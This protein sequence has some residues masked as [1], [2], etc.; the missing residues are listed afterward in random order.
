MTG[1]IAD[2]V[3]ALLSA[4]EGSVGPVTE[5][6]ALPPEMY[7][8]DQVFELEREAIFARDWLC[9][10][11]VDQ[12][13]EPGDYRTVT[14]AGEP[15]IVTRGRTGDIRVLSAV[16]Q[17]RGMIVVEG[18]GS[19]NK[20]TCPYHHWSYGLD[21]RLL[22]APAMERSAGFDKA[23]H[24]LPSLAVEIWNGFVFASM[25]PNPTP[26][27][28]TLKKVDELLANYR[29]A[30][31]VTREG[32]TLQDLPWNWKVMME[33]FNDPYHASRLHGPLQT[34]AP[35]HMNDYLDWD[36]GDGAVVRVQRFTHPDGSFNPTQKALMP[37]F[38]HLTDE[39]RSRGMFVLI[40]PTLAL[41]VVPDEI[42]YFIISPQS[43]GTITI[44]I[45]YCFDAGAL[46]HPL[47]EQLFAMAEAGV[48]NF[49]REDIY[50]DRMV[51]VG[52]RSRFAPRGR[53]SYQEETLRQL[54]RWLKVRYERYLDAE[55]RA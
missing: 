15:L 26:L 32:I 38:P 46:E 37:V 30:D 4:F 11:R 33:N 42:A 19:C 20:F 12:V 47:F 28:P 7:A 51:Q 40:P 5:S 29:L 14:I 49:N 2:R 41:A 34:F 13:P 45:S 52:L 18:S 50:A 43:A 1:Q 48:D 25:E 39:E 17:H 22:G 10:G 44:H 36:D 24:G 9:V 3:S 55:S 27:A 16:C 23:D 31:T 54:N 6:R 8:S 21:G 35:S 53:Y